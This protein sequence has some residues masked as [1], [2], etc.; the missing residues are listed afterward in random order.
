MVYG[1]C[2]LIFCIQVTF[3]TLLD[4]RSSATQHLSKQDNGVV[5]NFTEFHSGYARSSFS[6]NC[7]DSS[8]FFSCILRIII[9]IMLEAL[10]LVFMCEVYAV[11]A[12]R[13]L[14][15]WHLYFSLYKLNYNAKFRHLF[16]F[17]IYVR[18]SGY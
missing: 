18:Y 17:R 3:S 11:E 7:E 16:N 9:V 12:R 1:S 14:E 2:H 5:D 10:C 15:H 6:N 4:S 13:L 8:V